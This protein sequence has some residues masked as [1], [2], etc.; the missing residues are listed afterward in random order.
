VGE[1]VRGGEKGRKREKSWGEEG[2]GEREGGGREREG[3]G[4]EKRERERGELM[5]PHSFWGRKRE[6]E[7][8][9]KGLTHISSC[10]DQNHLWSRIDRQARQPK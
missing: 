5:T 4:R 7:K 10:E 2:E 8:M 1:G 9:G 3:G 6:E